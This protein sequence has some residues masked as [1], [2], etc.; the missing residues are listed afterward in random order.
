MTRRPIHSNYTT[1]STRINLLATSLPLLTTARFSASCCAPAGRAGPAQDQLPAAAL[2]RQQA[3]LLLQACCRPLL[4]ACCRPL[5]LGLRRTG[6]LQGAALPAESAA[7]AAGRSLPG[8]GAG[9]PCTKVLSTPAA[10][11]LTRARLGPPAHF[12]ACAPQR[13]KHHQRWAS[14]LPV[15]LHSTKKQELQKSPAKEMNKTRKRVKSKPRRAP[16]GKGLL[17]RSNFRK[18]PT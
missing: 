4:Q 8:L 17:S 18:S 9:R 12:P 5:L 13:A 14:L 16:G 10:A 11:A 15:E 6:L 1:V 7:A 3:Q 2:S